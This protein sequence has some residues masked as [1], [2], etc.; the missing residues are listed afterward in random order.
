MAIGCLPCLIVL[1]WIPFVPE[2]PRYLLLKDRADEAWEIIK[3]LHS[4]ADD[5]EHVYAKEEFA[6]MR[7]QLALDR[8]FKSGYVEMFRRPSYR[9]RVMMGMGLTFALQSSG[10]L[11]I[12]SMHFL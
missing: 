10:V 12:N 4:T 7:N 6:Q 11:V 5:V 1:I 2:S 8:T 9:K 3:E